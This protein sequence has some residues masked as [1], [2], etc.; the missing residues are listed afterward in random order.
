MSIY[1]Q[2]MILL[3]HAGCSPGISSD[4]EFIGTVLVT[5]ITLDVAVIVTTLVTVV[6]SFFNISI[7]PDEVTV[8]V[9]KSASRQMIT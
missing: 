8:E 3:G 5:V 4:N 1:C 2:N 6:V 9:R 7:N